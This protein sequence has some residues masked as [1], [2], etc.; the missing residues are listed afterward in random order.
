MNLERF[1][2]K[3][4]RVSHLRKR[5]HAPLKRFPVSDALQRADHAATAWV[6]AEQVPSRKGSNSFVGEPHYQ[7]HQAPAERG[8]CNHQD[9]TIFGHHLPHDKPERNQASATH[10]RSRSFHAGYLPSPPLALQT[11]LCF[12]PLLVF[13]N[14]G[15]AGR[16]NRRKGQK[17]PTHHRTILCGDDSSQTCDRASKQE[18]QSVLVPA[19][20]L[21]CR[22]INLDLHVTGAK[23]ATEVQRPRTTRALPTQSRRAR[24]SCRASSRN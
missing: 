20:L 4:Q 13:L 19:R 10:C 18:T 3:I 12:F 9:G 22:S 6:G 16:K 14:Q 17:Y 24:F 21:P 8:A 23:P 2:P 11:V 7:C 1:T 5:R 15:N